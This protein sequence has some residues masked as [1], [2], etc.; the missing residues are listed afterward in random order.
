MFIFQIRTS[1]RR[2]YAESGIPNTLALF[3]AVYAWCVPCVWL[4]LCVRPQLDLKE[5]DRKI[6]QQ[7]ARL[8]GVDLSR[9]VQQVSQE[10][11]ETQHRLDT[12]ETARTWPDTHLQTRTH[13]HTGTLMLKGP[14]DAFSCRAG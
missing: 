3:F 6:A 14:L 2:S 13:T 7:E 10:K 8:Q 1:V 11:Q 4:I 5:V 12:S 9:T